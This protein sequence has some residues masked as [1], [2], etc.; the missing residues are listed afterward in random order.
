MS[1]YRLRGVYL[2]AI[3]MSVKQSVT[4]LP[5]S[6]G[7]SCVPLVASDQRSSAFLFDEH[8]AKGFDLKHSGLASQRSQASK[9][10]R[11]LV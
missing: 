3:T 2:F 6:W 1:F 4:D 8:L 7:G 9:L 5:N 11:F 10:E